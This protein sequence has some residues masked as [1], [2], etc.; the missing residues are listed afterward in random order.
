MLTLDKNLGQKKKPNPKSYLN[1][2]ITR[3]DSSLSCRVKGWRDGEEEEELGAR[4]W[5]ELDE[6]GTWDDDSDPFT[7][8]RE[9]GTFMPNRGI[10]WP[11]GL[12]C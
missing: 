7:D 6:V 12:S 2:R 10:D 4:G 9:K 11:L 1:W 3:D 8:E 5:E